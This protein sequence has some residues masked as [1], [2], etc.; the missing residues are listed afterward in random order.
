M[1][2][3]TRLF[4]SLL[5]A[6]LATLCLSSSASI[7]YAAPT[8][9]QRAEIL[10]VGTLMTKAANLFKQGKFKES[11]DAVA[12][13]QSRIE[14]LAES[15]DA[16]IIEQLA[17]IHKRL[18]NAHALLELEG[19]KLTALKPLEAKKPMPAPGDAPAGGAGG[20][21]FTKEVA[22]IL[23]ARCGGCHVRGT[24][25]MFSMASYDVLMAG[26]PAGKVVFPGNIDGSD[27]VVKVQ[28]KE[29]PPSG[30]GIPDAELATLKKWVAEGAKFDGTDPKANLT[31]L[32][33]GNPAAAAPMVVVT[34]ATGKETIS[35][36]KDIAPVLAKSCTGCHGTNRPRE[37]FS[38][39]TF[40]D[41]LKGGDAGPPVLPGKPADSLLV[42][43]L[44]GTADGMRMPQGM[45]P[46]ADDVIAK[47]EKW[48]EEGAKF[49]GGNAKQ[50]VIEVAA[51]AKAN[52]SSHAELS[53]D[54]AMLA[55]TNWNLVL[56]DMKADKVETVNFLV[57]GNVGEN[58][59][60]DIGNQA[61]SLA[62]KIATMFKAPADQALLKGRVSLFVFRDRYDY[63]E[64]GK[65]VERRDLPQP[66]RGHFNYTIVD[67]YGAVVPPR[68]GDYSLQVL[69]GQQLA[70]AYVAS[71]GKGTPRWFAE[72]S[73]RVAASRIDGADSRVQKWD[74]AVL[75]VI[76][77][78]TAPDDFLTGKVP[79]EESDICSYSFVKFLMADAKRY[80]K[81]I[82]DLRGGAN[83]D[84]AFASTYG[85]SPSQIT[86]S[87]VRKPPAKSKP[88]GKK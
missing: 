63:S 28:D 68:A 24:R 47:V 51:L 55:Q 16:Q 44:K 23:V 52:A 57:L 20:T 49:D 34:A 58:T 14:K 46:L 61:E 70:G 37:N 36:S 33:A 87:W 29:M 66:W 88:A 54:R 4:P 31:A 42:K 32:T 7:A 17:P 62:P 27:L 80:Q 39:F 9:E 19:V 48:I 79:P 74:D 15:G 35:F 82:D 72:G 38:V 26:P 13:V 84:Q 67:A 60:A 10:S 86:Q 5:V 6:A 1:R 18:L 43:K 11:G 53:A 76:S 12:E 3:F 30:A 21:S 2:L 77:T 22:P 8:P 75:E 25:G 83:F 73:A 45:E 59:L 50:S 65:M 41:L 40:E 56:P 64:F 78:M 81:L 69:I 85:G 71:L